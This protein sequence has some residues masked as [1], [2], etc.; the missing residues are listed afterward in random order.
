MSASLL[1]ENVLCL[2]SHTLSKLANMVDFILY[3]LVQYVCYAENIANGLTLYLHLTWLISPVFMCGGA[4]CHKA[5]K[6]SFV[7]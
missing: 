1:L 5:H 3:Y 7:W 4:R 6:I 2:D